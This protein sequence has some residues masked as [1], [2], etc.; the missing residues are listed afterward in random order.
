MNEKCRHDIQ[1]EK[2]F[3]QSFL[4]ILKFITNPH[5]AF[6]GK[7]GWLYVLG[8]KIY[9]LQACSDT[10]SIYTDWFHK[11]HPGNE[12]IFKEALEYFINQHPN[13]EI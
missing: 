10:F 2:E 8:H 13:L 12:A 9:N 11:K 7:N 3:E 6:E 5:P 1:S 4:D